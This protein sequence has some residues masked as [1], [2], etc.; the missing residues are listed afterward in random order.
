MSGKPPTLRPVREPLIRIRGLRLGYGARTVMENVDLTIG[1][2]EFWFFLGQN[3]TGKTTMLNALTGLLRPL[4]GEIF[5]HPERAG[6]DRIG[7]VPQRCGMNPHLPTTVREFV[8]LGLAGLR[9]DRRSRIERLTGSLRKVGLEGREKASYWSLSGGQRQRVVVARAL[10]R[11]PDLLIMDEPTAGLDP[12]AEA[13]LLGDIAGLNRTDGLTVICVSHDLATAARYGSHV[14]LFHEGGVRTGT[15]REVLTPENIA[16]V[17]G[18]GLD[19]RWQNGAASE[20]D[21]GQGVSS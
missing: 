19:V 16:R 20:T 14:A 3:G 12:A 18:V 6:R 2:G 17:Y 13:A 1:P 4:S 21:N 8:T 11:H 9:T 15:V 7:F 5:R 10:A